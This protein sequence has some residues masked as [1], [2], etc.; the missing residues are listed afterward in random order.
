MAKMSNLLFLVLFSA[1]AQ[2][3]TAGPSALLPSTITTTTTGSGRGTIADSNT[4]LFS[5]LRPSSSSTSEEV[6]TTLVDT[7]R[8]TLQTSVRIAQESAATGASFKQIMAN[9]LAGDYDA[10]QVN[11]QLDEYIASA[12]CVMFVWKAS[13]SCQKAVQALE[14][15]AGA[16]VKMV[17]LDD[18]WDE[19]HPLRAELGKRT[20]KTS[21]P[22]VWI[23]GQY[24]G[25]FDAGVS[26]EESP[27]LVDL[28]FRGTLRSKL[29]AAGA[30]SK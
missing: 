15:V 12:P 1:A 16:N 14:V 18:P 28:A 5:S 21:V 23:G 19:G 6:P 22:S 11:A 26:K 20:G 30:L 3:F 27:G 25:G 2:A 24:V 29:E 4:C 7:W 17:P 13:P 10:D 9:V 8:E